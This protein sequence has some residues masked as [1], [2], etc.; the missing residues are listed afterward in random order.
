VQQ[1]TVQENTQVDAGQVMAVIIP[2]D[3]CE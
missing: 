3:K 1:L 2:S